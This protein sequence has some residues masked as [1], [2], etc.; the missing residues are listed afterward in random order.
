[1]SELDRT[2]SRITTSIKGFLRIVPKAQL[3]P[4]FTGCLARTPSPG[5]DQEQG[6]IPE[7]VVLQLQMMDEKLTSILAL[8]SQQNM[9]EDYPVP[10][11]VH[12]LSGAGLRFSAEQTFTLGERVEIILSL[13]MYPPG[14]VGTFG[15]IIRQD[16]VETT[17]LWVVKFS[18]IRSTEREK[19]IQYVMA[20]QREQLRDRH[21]H[22]V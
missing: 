6:S 5:L 3:R 13:S 10:V 21:A 9:R 8:L 1:M 22:Q 2:Y 20:E 18:A 17:N 12:D 19:I 11:L 4:L 7:S 14:L 16:T 15:T